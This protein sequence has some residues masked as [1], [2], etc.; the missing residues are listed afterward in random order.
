MRRHER[1][2]CRRLLVS[3]SSRRTC[4]VFSARSANRTPAVMSTSAADPSAR[5]TLGMCLLKFPL[6]RCT[7]G[8][9]FFSRVSLN[10]RYSLLFA[11]PITS[12]PVCLRGGGSTDA[13]TREGFT[14]RNLLFRT[15]TQL[16]FSGWLL[17]CPQ[18]SLEANDW[19][20]PS[21]PSS[22]F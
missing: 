19:L 17:L 16:L 20:A 11:G 21:S 2:S 22:T 7:T 6:C 10:F 13:S 1:R 12:N 18:I 15:V 9:L 5:L 3:R 14:E 8:M 4:A